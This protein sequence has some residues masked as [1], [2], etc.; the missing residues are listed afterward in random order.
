MRALI[1]VDVQNDFCPGGALAVKDG[2]AV[3]PV[4][5]RL[6]EVSDLVVATQDWHPKGHSSFASTHGR[7]PGDTVTLGG[8]AKTLWPDH[9]VEGTRGAELHGG[10]RLQK[11]AC[12]FQKGTDPHA[13]SFSGF[14]DDLRRSSGLAEYLRG[15]GVDEVFIAGLATDYC[16][17][18]TALDAANAG[19]S[20]TVVLDACRGVDLRPDDVERAIAELRA[21]G[22][23]TVES[24]EVL[25]W[26]Q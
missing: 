21:A 15:R 4:I 2:D 11:L 17:K 6:A 9:C 26:K 24:A 23:R 7:R 16:V 8:T 1:V 13:D 12:V 25:A 10:L 19:F 14:C 3:V 20:T 5:N 18:A 22:V